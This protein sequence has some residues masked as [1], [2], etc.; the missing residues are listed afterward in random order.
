MDRREFM[1]GAAATLT[2]AGVGVL[3]L[4]VTSYEAEAAPLEK[5]LDAVAVKEATEMFNKF[6]NNPK[7]VESLN[8]LN[9]KPGDGVKWAQ[10]PPEVFSEYIKSA[11]NLKDKCGVTGAQIGIEIPATGQAK[12]IMKL[13]IKDPAIFHQFSRPATKR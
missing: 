9:A 6:V 10:L 8:K 12:I 2:L 4:G 13:V 7:T 11:P 1:T 3:S 5:R